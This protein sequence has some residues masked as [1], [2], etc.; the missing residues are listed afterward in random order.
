M[1]FL[2]VRPTSKIPQSLCAF[3]EKGLQAEGLGIINIEYTRSDSIQDTLLANT[4]DI[5]IF[6]SSYAVVGFCQAIN[7]QYYAQYSN[8][9]IICVGQS[10]AKKLKNAI[11]SLQN[12][13][14]ASPANSEG[15][16]AMPDLQE[17]ENKNIVLFKGNHGRQIIEQSLR[18]AKAS[19]DV[20]EV[21]QRLPNHKEIKRFVFETKEIQC[22]I[23][24]SIEIID[25]LFKHFDNKQLQG[26]VWI[27]A[28]KRIKEYALSIGILNIFVSEGASIE[29]SLE[30]A[31][32]LVQ[33]GVVND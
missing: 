25:L 28:S 16:L 3:K 31:L 23:A 17:P 10:T 19:L 20:L 27:V 33:T 11:S 24:S 6:T 21:Y 7:P 13:K 14:I 8:T 22:I 18:Q 9:P 29:A 32:D 12:I 30:C 4:P 2:I 1:S 26:V 15:V 5:L